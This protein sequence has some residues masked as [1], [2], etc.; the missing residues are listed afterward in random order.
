MTVLLTFARPVSRS[1]KKMST[2]IC[3][4]TCLTDLKLFESFEPNHNLNKLIFELFLVLMVFLKRENILNWTLFYLIRWKMI[5]GHWVIFSNSIC[6][7]LQVNMV[8][9]KIKKNWE[10]LRKLKVSLAIFNRGACDVCF[11]DRVRRVST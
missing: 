3:L 11:V 8:F 2:K 6:Q 10:F 5:C 4:S 1:Y 9:Q 7:V